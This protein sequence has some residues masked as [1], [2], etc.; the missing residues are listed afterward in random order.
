MVYNTIPRSE[1][2]PDLLL[3]RTDSLVPPRR[4]AFSECFE[5]DL[6]DIKSMSTSTL[7]RVQSDSDLSR[8][9]RKKTFE[10]ANS[11]VQPSE[12]LA[13]VV[14]ALGNIRPP[15]EDGASVLEMA[16]GSKRGSG[17]VHGFSDSQIL[18][19][20]RTWSG[21]SLQ[22]SDKSFPTPP[23]NFRNR[24]ISESRIPTIDEQ[25]KDSN[26]W[27]WSGS[28]T[29]IKEL[30]KMRQRQRDKNDLYRAS[31]GRDKLDSLPVS[32]NI[33]PEPTT[34]ATNKSILKRLNPFKRKSV[35]SNK[36][37]NDSIDESFPQK[38]DMRRESKMSLPRH[39]VSRERTS[40]YSI[41]PQ[42]ADEVDQTLLETTTIAD[43]IRAIEVVHTKVHTD[44]S[45]SDITGNLNH[46]RRKI[47]IASMT[48]PKA[49]SLLTL[50][51]Q[52]YDNLSNHT[53]SFDRRRSSVR[54]TIYNSIRHNPIAMARRQS[55]IVLG[56]NE[57]PPPY[58]SNLNTPQQFTGRFS[59][60]PSALSIPP[61]QAPRPQQPLPGS[62][63]IPTNTTIPSAQVSTSLQRKLSLRPSPLN[64]FAAQQLSARNMLWR[65]NQIVREDFSQTRTRHGSLSNLY[66]QNQKMG[67][68]RTDSK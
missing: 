2:C 40:V 10:N 54:P 16:I 39:Y 19:S 44:S 5:G 15:E 37:R 64:R 55:A 29:Q 11:L 59:V 53:N 1:S 8:I 18:D 46:P 43:L 60:R 68:S 33:P 7:N 12:L 32:I 34:S 61:G 50:F 9:D 23:Q 25:I 28:N 57:L 4:R 52:N 47:G 3:Y 67:R 13:K 26:E 58:V 56:R 51:P 17:G 65:P 20:E 6:K 30:M 21:W 36:I 42:T 22:S 24:A 48:P 41:T 45:S 27:T 38:I 49:P 62:S 63:I 35:T 66:E 14:T 31:F